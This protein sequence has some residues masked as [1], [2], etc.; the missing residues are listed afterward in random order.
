MWAYGLLEKKALGEMLSG[1]Q[2]KLREKEST[3]ERH[4]YI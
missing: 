2:T 4:I 3:Q 1:N